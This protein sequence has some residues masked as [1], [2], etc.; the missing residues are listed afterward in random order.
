MFIVIQE[1]QINKDMNLLL[2]DSF[3]VSMLVKLLIFLS[4]IHGN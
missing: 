2:H 4:D 1:N 3:E